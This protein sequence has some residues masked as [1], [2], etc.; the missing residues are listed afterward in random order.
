MGQ[1]LYDSQSKRI[2]FETVEQYGGERIVTATWDR[3]LKC[4][5]CIVPP[6][7]WLFGGAEVAE[8]EL[9]RIKQA[10]VSVMLTF[11]N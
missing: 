2:K 3:K 9:E 5:Q 11:N 10:P 8:E 7:T 6:L 4:L 1:G